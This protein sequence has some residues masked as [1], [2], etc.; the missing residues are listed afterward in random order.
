MKK[1]TKTKKRTNHRSNYMQTSI[2]D[3]IQEDQRIAKEKIRTGQM[4]FPEEEELARSI[5]GLKSRRKKRKHSLTKILN[6]RM[7]KIHESELT[8][9]IKILIEGFDP[10]Q[11]TKKEI[12]A[13]RKAL[14][15]LSKEKF[16]KGARKSKGK[17]KDDDDDEEKAVRPLSK[18]DQV[19]K[20]KK[21][22]VKKEIKPVEDDEDEDEED[23]EDDE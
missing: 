4:M 20:S 8:E 7:P 3:I 17:K 21:K 1:T 14:Q 15:E 16:P 23:E 10:E 19:S 6:K 2:L 11:C 9:S 18:K 5:S 12:R 22:A 13:F